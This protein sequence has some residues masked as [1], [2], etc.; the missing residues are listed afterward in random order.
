M[1]MEFHD[2]I[3]KKI[4]CTWLPVKGSRKGKTG[5]STGRGTTGT[6]RCE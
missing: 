5:K 4:Q 2:I 6:H 1:N 3:K